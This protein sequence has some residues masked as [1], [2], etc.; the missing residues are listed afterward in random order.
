MRN[1]LQ[2]QSTVWRVVLF[3]TLWLASHS[4]SAAFLELPLIVARKSN[5]ENYVNSHTS[6]LRFAGFGK[7]KKDSAERTGSSSLLSNV[8]I[9]GIDDG[10]EESKRRQRRKQRAEEFQARRKAW[11]DK[12]GSADALCRT[13][14]GCANPILG[15]L[16]GEATR[17]L[18]HTLLPR[19]LWALQEADILQPEELAPL[20]YQAR[21][22]AKEYAR[23]RSKLPTRLLAMAFDGY[24][25]WK[26]D[27]N[28]LNTKGLTWQDLWE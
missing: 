15:D 10:P 4:P 24:R 11:E 9:V 14:G 16:D 13:F 28:P 1:P 6:A 18:Y 8:T 21:M 25:S 22:A 26:R 2:V 23:R 12:Y 19:S 27:G 7:K 20:A 5:S 17:Q 3:L